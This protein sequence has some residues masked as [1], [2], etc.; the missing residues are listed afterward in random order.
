[1]ARPFRAALPLA[2]FL[3]LAPILA[4]TLI[5]AARARAGDTAPTRPCAIAVN[6]EGPVVTACKEGGIPAAKTKMKSML[7]IA[8][9]KQKGKHWACDECHENEENWRL[10][11]GARKRFKELVA[12]VG[13]GEPAAAAQ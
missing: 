13:A 9:G 8:R 1:M 7:G 10:E 6:G 3:V 4:F 12:L 11:T 5:F 2:G